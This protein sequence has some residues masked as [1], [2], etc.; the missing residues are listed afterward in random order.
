MEIKEKRF[1]VVVKP[2]SSKNEFLGF[3]KEKNAYQIKI[4]ESAENNKAN[5]ELINFL[6][7]HIKKR[8][9]IISGFKSKEKVIE[10]L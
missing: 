9:K 6:S 7:K 4:K 3:D 10:I 8:V 1:C 2:N 5:I